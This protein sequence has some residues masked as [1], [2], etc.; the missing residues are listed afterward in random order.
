MSVVEQQLD[1]GVRWL[2]ERRRVVCALLVDAEGSS[3]FAPGAFMLIDSDG[4]I[5]GSITGGCVES[6]VVVNALEMLEGDGK[7][8]LL[9][10]GVSDAAAHEVG[11]M[12]GG[13]VDV[14]VHELDG[15]SRAICAEAW[16]AAVAGRTAG[17]ATLLGG[18]APA[19]KLAVIEGRV[20]GGLH[21][22]ELLDHS[23]TRDLT[24]LSER[25]T[26]ALRHYG[27]DGAALGSELSVH[28][29][30]FRPAPQLVLIGAIDYSAAVAALARQA[31]YDVV[32]ADAREAFARSER[33]SRVATVH[34][35]WP[36][37]AIDERQLGP[38][39]AVIVFSHDAKF[40]EPAILAALR[41][42]AGYIGALGSHRTARDRR[43]RLLAAG[44]QADEL[45]RVHS[46]CGLDIGAATPEEVAISIMAEVIAAR[47]GRVG[48]PLITTQ[49]SIRPR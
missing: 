45:E 38:R 49:E 32:I 31:G 17:I 11:L 33:F 8:R 18:P 43:E 35:G 30:A 40:D 3:P 20:L 5:E 9:T 24:A 36:G 14:F 4:E 6:D 21:G 10:Y 39:D 19:A 23:V 12:C 22:P 44:A 25:G 42:E 2:G 29:Q 26:S 13:T 48:T 28:L 27:E 37:P 1:I 16:A 7:P 41:S 34:V 15:E 47:S 46:P